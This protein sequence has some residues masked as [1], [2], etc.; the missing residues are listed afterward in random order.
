MVILYNTPA[1]NY[2]LTLSQKLH[3]IKFIVHFEGRSGKFAKENT[4]SA[5]T[6]MSIEN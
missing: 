6:E 3:I 5:K 2:R 1:R 4:S